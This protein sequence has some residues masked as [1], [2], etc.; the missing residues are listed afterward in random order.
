M[1]ERELFK[2]QDRID[3]RSFYER[4]DDLDQ[5]RNERNAIM[6]E[7]ARRSFLVADHIEDLEKEIS[8]R[9]SK[10]EFE[11]LSPVRVI[12]KGE[13]AHAWVGAFLINWLEDVAS[14]KG[15]L[16]KFHRH[17]GVR[18][19]LTLTPLAL[20]VLDA[21]AQFESVQRDDHWYWPTLS[22]Q[23]QIYRDLALKDWLFFIKPL[24][25]KRSLDQ[26]VIDSIKREINGRAI[27]QGAKGLD[28]QR[29]GAAVQ[30]AL[31]YRRCR[32]MVR[33]PSI[34]AKIRALCAGCDSN[35]TSART[36]VDGLFNKYSALMVLRV[37]L[38]FIKAG[39]MGRTAED[40]L[41]CRKVFFNSLR[42][43]TLGKKILG[44]IWVLEFCPRA[45]FHF[46]VMVFM[47][48]NE[49]FR[50]GHWSQVL[51]NAW[52]NFFGP[53]VTRGNNCSLKDYKERSF[54]GVVQ[55]HDAEKIK[56][57]N[58]NLAYLCKKTQFVQVK[59][60]SKVKCFG[61]SR[62]P[63]LSTEKVKGRRRKYQTVRLAELTSKQQSAVD[64]NVPSWAKLV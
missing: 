30:V 9:F 26:R 62:I 23:A 32:A 7:M 50:D 2:K 43:T 27:T 51:I 19:H 11:K 55:H 5:P 60:S 28:N 25:L 61:C 12:T 20:R 4:F 44:Y 57:L 41:D 22:G 18:T 31:F 52:R 39:G 16:I 21:A 54:L 56:H 40:A 1:E 46:H 34:N 47:N 35:L 13:N 45:G 48:G 59:T 29:R 24:D 6:E 3:P 37:D 14:G 53:G 36:L 38:A 8:D 10:E 58:Y 17:R 63:F 64:Q 42:T 33:D 15:A 49:S